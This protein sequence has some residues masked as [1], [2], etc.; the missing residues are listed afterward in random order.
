M[1]FYL[2]GSPLSTKRNDWSSIVASFVKESEQLALIH[3]ADVL[4]QQSPTGL[5]IK[6]AGLKVRGTISHL[7]RAKGEHYLILCWV[8]LSDGSGSK[9]AWVR[10]SDE[11]ALHH[12]WRRVP[13]SSLVFALRGR[14]RQSRRPV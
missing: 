2:T 14:T 6:A 3:R 5:S 1:P 8:R 11:N 13:W 7:R 4:H 12:A 9:V 10:E